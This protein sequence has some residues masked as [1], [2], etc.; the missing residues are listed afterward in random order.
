MIIVKTILM[1]AVLMGMVVLLLSVRDLGRPS[2]S[3]DKRETE[4]MERD[5]EQDELPIT[6]RSVFSGFLARDG[7]HG[8]WPAG[9]KRRAEAHTHR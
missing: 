1:I 6:S 9:H 2:Q 8:G 7:K 4:E 3:T 5:I